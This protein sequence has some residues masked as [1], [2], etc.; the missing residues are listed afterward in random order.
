[1]DNRLAKNNVRPQAAQSSGNIRR[2]TNK[3]YYEKILTVKTAPICAFPP[4]VAYFDTDVSK[5]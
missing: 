2:F 1:M 5:R 4:L 3:H